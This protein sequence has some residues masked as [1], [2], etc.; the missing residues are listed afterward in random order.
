MPSRTHLE[1][2]T[3]TDVGAVDPLEDP[4]ES[5]EPADVTDA[6]AFEVLTQRNARSAS[7]TTPPSMSMTIPNQHAIDATATEQTTP[8]NIPDL[9]KSATVVISRFPSDNA[10]AP[11]PSLTQGSLVHESDEDT[12]LQSDWAPFVSQCDWQVAH[13]A[14]MRGSTSSAVTELLAIGEVRIALYLI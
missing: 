5:L 11:I 3:R 4:T 14:K 2:L 13:W 8:L 1:C 12:A 7:M 6:D 10:G 9:E